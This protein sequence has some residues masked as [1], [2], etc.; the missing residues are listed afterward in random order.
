MFEFRSPIAQSLTVFFDVVN[1]TERSLLSVLRYTEVPELPPRLLEI[2]ID[3]DRIVCTFGF[4]ELHFLLRLR[5]SLLNC[6]FMVCCAPSKTLLEYFGGG[7]FDEYET[8]I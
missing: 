7:R 3:Y 4:G 2:V 5:Q 8:G 6:I 1:R